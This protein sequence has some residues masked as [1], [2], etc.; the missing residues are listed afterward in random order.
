MA[1]KY[2]HLSDSERRR[3]ERLKTSGWSVRSIARAL[4]RGIG[5]ISEE[6]QRNKVKGAYD[7]R[8]AGHKARVRRQYSKQQ[9]LKV[10]SNRELQ[11]YVE[12]KLKEEWSPELIAGRIRN[13]DRHLPR[14]SAK[15]IYAFVY[16]VHGRPFEQFLYSNMVHGKGGPKRGS[17]TVMDG[18]TSIEKRPKRVEKR[19]QFG[20]FEGDFI[21]SGKDGTGSFLVLAERKTRYPFIRYCLD[22]STAAV[23]EMIFNLLRNI[24]LESLTLDN[25]LS[26]QKHKALSAL[27]D[28]MVFFCHPY[29]SS[30]KG[31]VENRNRAIRRTVPKKTDLSQVSEETIRM[32]E[33]KLRNRPMKCL[34]FRTP[35]EAWDAEMK[36]V[37]QKE[38]SAIHAVSLRVL[39][40]NLE[41]SA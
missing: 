11:I 6:I 8:K 14:V 39:K 19:A 4:G 9:C 40:A 29:T 23:N 10:T 7:A 13:I 24:P 27:I 41:C 37:E 34:N 2:E 38:K 31:T 17:S 15:A 12:E 30:E 36:K 3:I 32:I 33:T 28:A 1:K 22:R 26:F 16:S 25:D 21:E 5:T 18:R 20:H 35:Q